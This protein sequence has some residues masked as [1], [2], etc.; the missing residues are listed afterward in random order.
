MFISMR[1]RNV[2][3]I[4]TLFSIVILHPVHADVGT[5]ATVNADGTT[6]VGEVV[7]SLPVVNDVGIDD[8]DNN[9][10]NGNADDDDDDD[11]D[12]NANDGGSLPHIVGLGDDDYYYGDFEDDTSEPAELDK[13]KD[14]NCKDDDER[15]GFWASQDECENN[16]GYMLQKCKKSCDVCGGITPKETKIKKEGLGSKY[17]EP[18]DATGV[19]R[20]SV[21]ERIA[22]MEKY[23][24]EE[25]TKPKYDK[26]RRQCENRNALCAF[27]AVQGECEANPS[28][29]QLHCPPVC[30]TCDLLDISTRC[31]KDPNVVDAMGPGDLN[32]MFERIVAEEKGV[33]ILSRPDYAEGDNEENATYNIGPWIVTVDDFIS[34]EECDRLIELGGNAGYERSTDVGKQKFDGTF[35]AVQSKTRTSAN[36]WC[37]DACFKDPL[38]KSALASIERLTGVPDINSEYLQLL[39]YQKGQ[40]YRR[41]H[42][43]IE[44]TWDRAPGP[45]I[46]TAFLYLNDVEAGGGTNFPSLHL[47]VMP[48]KGKILLWPSVLNED[49][50]R[51]DFRTDHQALDV[52]AGEKYAANAWIHLRDFK[53]P[54]ET[55]CS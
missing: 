18:Q 53:T 43:Y 44:A 11:D 4:A 49:P 38:V 29:M 10:S 32:K 25:V 47:T 15:C 12:H 41:H 2:F 48:K 16:P 17:G 31:P 54:H 20:D 50:N 5:E 45:R 22:K 28:Y 23:M 27:W 21:L 40:F 13:P 24:E 7:E 1:M 3:F 36:A 9:D 42:D 55:G 8:N 30:E 35:D 39:K 6:N 37:T 19:H 34:D 14:E 52:E 26:V 33:T 46:L 51:K